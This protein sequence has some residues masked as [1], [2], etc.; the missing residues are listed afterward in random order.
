MAMRVASL[1]EG[2]EETLAVPNLDLPVQLRSF[3]AT[4]NAI[5]NTLG[6]VRRVTR[7]VKEGTG[8]WC[9]AGRRLASW[10]R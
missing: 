4:T 8:A 2:M 6:T 3:L 5:E 10:K 1:R 9:P 7:N